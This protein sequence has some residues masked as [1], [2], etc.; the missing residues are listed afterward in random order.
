M[1]EDRAVSTGMARRLLLA[2]RTAVLL[3]PKTAPDLRS[4]TDYDG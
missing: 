4:R 1:D 3:D 2:L